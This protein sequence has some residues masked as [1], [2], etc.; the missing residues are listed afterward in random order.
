MQHEGF[1]SKTGLSYP[2]HCLLVSPPSPHRQP[3]HPQSVLFQVLYTLDV[4]QYAIGANEEGNFYHCINKALQKREPLLLHQLS[5]QVA[6][7]VKQHLDT[8]DTVD[9][10]L[11]A[12]A[13][14]ARHGP[15]VL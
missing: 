10:Q 9:T 3:F 13:V 7:S 4:S 6:L 15:L 2:A 14:A 8:N 11:S 5:G 1:I 12:S